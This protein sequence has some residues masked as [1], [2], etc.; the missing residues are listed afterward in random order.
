MA[1]LVREAAPANSSS[2]QQLATSNVPIPAT[3]ES[4]LALT[5]P[6]PFPTVQRSI[7]PTPLNDPVQQNQVS[8]HIGGYTVQQAHEPTTERLD[9]LTDSTEQVSKTSLDSDR[10]FV[11]APR[12]FGPVRF[13]VAGSP[14]YPGSATLLALAVSL[15]MTFHSLCLTL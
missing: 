14:V 11:Y 10:A 6:A 15:S 5:V 4:D 2:N 13:A 12:C 3:T 1:T 8:N 9:G 7:K